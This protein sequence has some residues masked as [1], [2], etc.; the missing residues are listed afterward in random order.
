MKIADERETQKTTKKR[1]KDRKD[2]GGTDDDDTRYVLP[3]HT[4]HSA[5]GRSSG[6][7]DTSAIPYK[8]SITS[9]K[10][11]IGYYFLALHHL[12]YV[13]RFT[14]SVMPTGQSYEFLLLFQ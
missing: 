7:C 9:Y 13:I 10:A 1:N 5:Y 3:T 6:R 4:S 8:A 14:S 11:V 2:Q 12:A